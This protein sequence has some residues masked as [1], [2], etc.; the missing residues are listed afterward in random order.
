MLTGRE[1]EAL[2]ALE[3]ALVVDPDAYN[4]LVNLG[5]YYQNRGELETAKEKFLRALEV[6]PSRHSLH[7]QVA[8]LLPPT[9]GSDSEILAARNTFERNLDA[10]LDPD[11]RESHSPLVP[12]DLRIA[13]PLR[14]LE[15][16]SKFYLQYH[17]VN[18]RAVQKKTASLMRMTSPS[19]HW[20]APF[21]KQPPSRASSERRLRIGFISKFFV[22]NHAHGQ[23]L[24]GVIEHLPRDRFEVFIFNIANPREPLN[25]PLMD[26]ADHVIPIALSLP[27]ARDRIAAQ[28]LD[29]LVFADIMSE[30]MNYFLAFSKLARIQCVFWGNPITSG[31]DTI[32]YFMTADATENE[33]TQIHTH[34]SEQAVLLG[35]Q[36]IWYEEIDV[37]AEE[38]RPPRAAYG[39][40]DSWLLYA[41]PQS[42]FKLHPRFDRAL[43]RILEANDH[44]HVMFV[45]GRNPK[46]TE[47]VRRRLNNTMPHMKE[48]I[49]F[50]PRVPGSTPF[51]KMISVAD[52]VLHPFPFGGSKTSADALALHLPLVVLKEKFLR[53]HMAPAFFRTMDL[54]HLVMK[55]EDDYVNF[56][57]QLADRAQREAFSSLLRQRVPRIW[58]NMTY[59]LDWG[60]FFERAIASV[61]WQPDDQT[62]AWLLQQD[63]LA[64]AAVNSGLTNA[65]LVPQSEQPSL[66][67]QPAIAAQVGKLGQQ[68]VQFY[69]A[70]RVKEAIAA[71]EQAIALDP[72]NAG[73]FNDYGA[74]L[75]NEWRLDES[76]AAFRSAIKLKP[77]GYAT[78]YQNLGVVCAAQKLFDESLDSYAH[79]LQLTPDP[80]KHDQLIYNIGG[81]LR[82]MHDA[83]SI[84]VMAKL[85]RLQHYVLLERES[86]ALARA[87]SN[88]SQYGRSLDP[89]AAVVALALIDVDNT[90]AMP[91]E[92]RNGIFAL[93]EN[94]LGFRDLQIAIA[95]RAGALEN[96]GAVEAENLLADVLRVRKLYPQAGLTAQSYTCFEHGAC[97]RL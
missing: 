80:E 90:A 79:A 13:E 86:T 43:K 82:D 39:L 29:V 65:H 28:E 81:L 19:L 6:E 15:Q 94:D 17:G 42:V 87:G 23:L 48:R 77:T 27:E 24:H 38:D 11:K 53:G 2:N 35:G 74:V 45:E 52:V 8:F 67:Y 33:N 58:R 75:K 56:A 44:A 60:R 26:A 30:Q 1:E 20:V 22:V 40:Q 78:A 72:T 51:L 31:I 55:T 61:E 5:V 73:L 34:Y 69:N 59:V 21:L 93:L 89:L 85:C 66:S 50:M 97:C 4:A 70:G 83:S 10:L 95:Q 63:H 16:T 41:C 14:S 7:V 88:T 92:A 64:A 71:L 57:V 9:L 36:G 96:A 76:R 37:P 3:R 49:H 18:D 68:A 62:R 12:R 84:D 54:E 91:L 32:D 47:S 25:E 46:W